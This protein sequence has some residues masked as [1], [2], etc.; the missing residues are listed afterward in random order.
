MERPG[1]LAIVWL[2]NSWA[3][4]AAKKGASLH[5]NFK[6]LLKKVRAAEA[7]VDL[8]DRIFSAES[9]GPGPSLCGRGRSRRAGQGPA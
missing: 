8:V 7:L 6:P 3:D 4:K 5:G 2:G 1:A 9:G